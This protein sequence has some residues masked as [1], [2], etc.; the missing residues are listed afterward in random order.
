V[1]EMTLTIQFGWWL[2]PLAL[3]VAA[4]WRAAYLDRDNKPGGDYN[5]SGI[6]SAVYYGLA[7]IVSLAVWLVWA[8]LV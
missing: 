7:L 2:L 6:V 3:T 4:F 8:L 5:M 1:S